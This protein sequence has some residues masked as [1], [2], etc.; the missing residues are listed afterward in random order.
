MD[1]PLAAQGREQVCKTGRMLQ[2]KGIKKILCSPLLRCRQT[3]EALELPVPC[4]FNELLREIDFGRWEGKTFAEIVDSDKELVDSWTTA[5]ESFSFPEGESVESFKNRV[6]ACKLH[7]E[8]LT[9]DHILVIA[10]GGIIR[11]LLC[12]LLGFDSHKY[13]VFDVMPGCFSSIR[14]FAEGG[15]LTGFNIQG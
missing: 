5:P 12:L 11:H 10:H 13:L 6:A 4:Q 9:D 3:L 2:D 7:L 14:L 1:V 15:V 8:N